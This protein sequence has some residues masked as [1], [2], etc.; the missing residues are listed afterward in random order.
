MLWT[1]SI[2]EPILQSPH[3]FCRVS[4]PNSCINLFSAQWKNSFFQQRIM[5]LSPRVPFFV[6][7]YLADTY[8]YFFSGCKTQRN[9]L[10]V[11]D[12]IIKERRY[13]AMKGDVVGT[14]PASAGVDEL[15]QFLLSSLRDSNSRTVPVLHA[16]G[17]LLWSAREKVSIHAVCIETGDFWFQWKQTDKINSTERHNPLHRVGR[18][19]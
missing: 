13:F 19:R 18:K 2:G 5:P 7:I 6:I 3:G 14:H 11:F 10:Q 15:H 4:R 17:H 16:H 12:K 1:A 9:R 8:C